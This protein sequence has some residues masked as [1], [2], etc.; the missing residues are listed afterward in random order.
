MTLYE[1]AVA[2]KP[3]QKLI[4]QDLPLRAAYDLAI[5]ATKLNPSLEFF[6]EQ[7][8][9]GRSLEEL[10]ALEADVEIKRVELPLDL[11]IKLTASDVKCLEPFVKFTEVDKVD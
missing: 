4:S 11:D 6:G 1:I 7:L 5:M 9:N 3:L 8:A 2:S 10:N